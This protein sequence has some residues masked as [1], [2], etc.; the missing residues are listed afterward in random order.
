VATLTLRRRRSETA[1]IPK[2]LMI[3]PQVAGS[4]T[5]DSLKVGYFMARKL[6]VLTSS[7]LGKLDMLGMNFP[8]EL[9]L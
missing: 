7:A 9:S 4:G 3:S 1:A 5:A 6:N 8:S 2:P